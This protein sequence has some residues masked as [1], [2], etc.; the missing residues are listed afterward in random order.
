M[1]TLSDIRTDVRNRLI[2]TTADFFTNAELLTWI[3]YGYKNF[4]QRT[5]WLEK[6][7]AYPIVA[8]QY[9]YTLPSDLVKVQKVRYRDNQ[10]VE[11]QD[12]EEWFDSVGTFQGTGTPPQIYRLFPWHSTLRIYP[13]P[14]AASEATTVNGAH[15]S[16]VT[17]IALTDATDF[18]SRGVVYI[19]S[20]EQVRYTAKSGNNLTGCI[21]GDGGTTAG[22][23]AGSE[24]VSWAE[25][26][27]YY[28]Y[29]PTLLSGD[30]DV[31]ATPT[32]YDEVI[33]DYALGVGLQKRDKYPL[34]KQHFAAAED[35]FRRALEER[36][37]MQRDRH[38]NFKDVSGEL[39]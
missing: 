1:T 33:V 22:T 20:S 30:S 32:M 9:D 17:T 35:G 10:T 5:E 19:N 31:L 23:Y 38:F 6:M 28:T 2:E 39:S 3:N 14:S 15:S 7:R 37:K 34:A 25:L 4:V 11:I 24:A 16:S 12:L 29:M 21:R 13:I 18:P 27:I 26:E 8:N 36:T